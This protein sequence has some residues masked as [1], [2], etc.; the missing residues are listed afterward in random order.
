MRA[1]A[2]GTIRRIASRPDPFEVVTYSAP[3]G[4][5]F[6]SGPKWKAWDGSLAMAILKDQHLHILKLDEAGTKV[7]TE[8][9]AVSDRGR[10]RSAVFRP[11]NGALYLVTDADPGSIIRVMPTG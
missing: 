6:L 1:T 7:V 3:S 11:S 2:L 4:A 8:W 9:E 10:L 5:V